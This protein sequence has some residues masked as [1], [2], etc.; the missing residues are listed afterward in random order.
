M[1]TERELPFAHVGFGQDAEWVAANF[2]NATEIL[3]M[4]YPQWVDA[5]VGCGLENGL[6]M[7]TAT[8]VEDPP[9]TT[10]LTVGDYSVAVTNAGEYAFLLEKAVEYQIEI[11][12]SDAGFTFAVVD[13]A[14]TGMA[15]M[16]AQSAYDGSYDG[17]WTDDDGGFELS[18]EVP[19][20]G[21]LLRRGGC[22][23]RPSIF[24]TPVAWQPTHG[25][26]TETFTVAVADIPFWA[27]P[28]YHWHADDAEAFSIAS[29]D[30]ATTQITC[31]FSLEHMHSYGLDVTVSVGDYVL[32]STFVPHRP[33][34]DPTA[35]FVS[36]PATM[37]INNDDDNSD[38]KIDWERPLTA[39]DDDVVSGMIELLPGHPTNG[40]VCVETISGL[41]GGFGAPDD[42]TGLYDSKFA[43]EAIAAGHS[44]RVDGVSRWKQGLWFNPSAVSSHYNGSNVKVTWTPD[45]GEPQSYR[46]R[47]TVVEPIVEPICNVVTNVVENGIA[48]CYTVNP[49][50]VAVGIGKDAVFHR[51]GT[52]C[53]T[54]RSRAGTPASSGAGRDRPRAR[55]R[56]SQS[57]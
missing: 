53:V 45:E 48:H 57:A 12:P 3:A 2:T 29:P 1:F 6:Y 42:E 40:T 37:F 52:V 13:D 27:T 46:R 32:S 23:W 10:W 30:S 15:T 28:R 36:A 51:T 4:G 7:L 38:G 16:S 20:V 54:A 8:L 49:C 56:R 44:W 14:P 19:I 55:R 35:F 25:E 5:Q 47:F 24:V 43:G 22:V 39:A 26:P 21:G 33:E 18:L 50:G 9:E 31:L 41:V 11:S 17:R 34:D